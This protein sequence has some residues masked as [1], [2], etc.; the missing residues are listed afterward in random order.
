MTPTDYLAMLK[1]MRWRD[2]HLLSSSRSGSM[3]Q[4]RLLTT[5]SKIEAIEAALADGPPEARWT[6]DPDGY[7]LELPEA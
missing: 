3:V 1:Q 4:Q 6:V 2:I 5:Q 7:P